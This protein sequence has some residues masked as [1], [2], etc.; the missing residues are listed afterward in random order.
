[1]ENRDAT[2]G[3]VLAVPASPLATGASLRTIGSDHAN[4]I[5]SFSRGEDKTAVVYNEKKREL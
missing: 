3:C 1:M 2:L 5:R 4:Y